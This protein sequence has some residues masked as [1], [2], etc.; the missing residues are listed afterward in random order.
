ML[1]RIFLK[2]L[3]AKVF[4][5]ICFLTI[6]AQIRVIN[7]KEPYRFKDTQAFQTSDGQG[8]VWYVGG[9]G[10]LLVITRGNRIEKRISEVDLNSLFFA[11]N[12]TAFVVGNSGELLVTKN[13]GE[14]WNK[15]ELNTKVNLESIFCLNKNKCWIVG[16]KDGLLISGGI[17][18][19]W[20]TESIVNNGKLTDVYF[21]NENTGFVVGRDSLVLKTDDGGKNWWRIGLSYKTRVTEF[22][23]GDFWFESVSF[24]DDRIGCVTGWDV[25]TGIVACT[26]DQGKNWKVNLINETFEGIIW[27]SKTEVYLVGKYGK[28]YI[29]KDAG[30][31]W[32]LSNKK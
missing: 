8:E 28:N 5:S 10:H 27:K 11:D 30:R 2:S 12:Q 31:T 6:N 13:R 19:N 9:S 25:G 16:N 22:I 15:I 18:G 32:E 1:M 24:L 26:Y 21:I 3:F 29:S 23:G 7:F 14:D 17:D 4:L 20:K